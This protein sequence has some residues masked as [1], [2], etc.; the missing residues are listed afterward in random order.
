MTTKESAFPVAAKGQQGFTLI[1][2]M[3]AL[4]LGLLVSVGIIALFQSTNNT[5]RV[6][7]AQA[8]LQENG[9][10]AISRLV[11]DI[12]MG[13]GQPITTDATSA[14]QSSGEFVQSPMIA[15]MVYVANLAN[16]LPRWRAGDTIVP[17]T[18]TAARPTAPYPLS[19]RWLIQGHEC[20]VGGATCNPTVP[21]TLPAIGTAAGNRVQG[22]DVL[23][24]RYIASTGWT[25]AQEVGS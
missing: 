23:T 24:V 18:F 19:P 21:A 16:L 13:L 20:D 9:R 22:A 17:A 10:Y 12:R 5:N 7:D 1:E 8:R 4:A 3:V 25:I 15:P 2:L 11:D 6:Q 14:N